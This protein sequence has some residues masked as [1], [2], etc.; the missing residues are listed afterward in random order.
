MK[1]G[2]RKR[3]ESEKEQ[4]RK[5]SKEYRKHA[6]KALRV[7]KTTNRRGEL[8]DFISKRSKFKAK[9]AEERKTDKELKNIELREMLDCK[10]WSAI[11]RKV[12]Q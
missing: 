11:W 9:Q 1:I 2:S 7:F 10:D 12:A 4:E 6:E 5:L 8:N 3:R